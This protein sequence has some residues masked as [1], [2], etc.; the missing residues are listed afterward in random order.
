MINISKP[1]SMS[2]EEIQAWEDKDK[3]NRKIHQFIYEDKQGE[4][5]VFFVVKPTAKL[6]FAMADMA[7]KS[8]EKAQHIIINGCVKAGPMQVLNEEMEIMFG[9]GDDINELVEVKKRNRGPG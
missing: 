9:L 8:T 5:V 4:D 2:E 7:Q 1:I 3:N 6:L